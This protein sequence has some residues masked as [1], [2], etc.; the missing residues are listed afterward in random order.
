MGDL[1]LDAD[2]SAPLKPITD[3]PTPLGDYLGAQAGNALQ[4]IQDRWSYLQGARPDNTVIGYTPEG[5]AIYGSDPAQQHI[6]PDQAQAQLDAAGVKM[7]APASGMYQD[8][9]DSLVDR[10]QD[11]QARAAAIAGSPTGFRSVLGFGV[12]AA[13]SMLDPINVA[14]AF[15]PVIGP[16]KY[17]ALLA[18]AGSGL[19][20]FGIRAAVGAA[21]G[22]AGTAILQPFDYTTARNF[23][24]DFTM[25]N[26]LENVAFG[27]AFGAGLHSVGGAVHDLVA[28]APV[29]PVV[30]TDIPETLPSTPTN[31]PDISTRAGYQPITIK[32]AT[33]DIPIS[34]LGSAWM[35]NSVSHETRI[36]ATSTAVG[37]LLDG[38]NI[39][40]TPIIRADPNFQL[41]MAMR[42]QPTDMAGALAQAR[43]DVEPQLRADLT[44]QAGNQAD[45][46]AITQMRDQLDQINAEL[47][48]PAVASKED[49]RLLQSGQKLKF[50]DAQARAQD[51]LNARRA[52][53]QTQADRLTQAID[54]NRQASQAAQDLA[55]LD[56]G[57]FPERYQDRLNARAEELLQGDP[58]TAAIRQLYAPG[59]EADRT[60]AQAYNAPE[61]VAVADADMARAADEHMAQ[62][63][64]AIKTAG[65]EGAELAM[66]D[67]ET[68]FN[69]VLTNLKQAGASDSLIERF[70]RELEPFNADL[71]DSDNLAAAVR[72]AAICGLSHG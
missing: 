66:A 38:R 59:P 28:G 36:A 37:Q 51:E 44:A 70:Q 54:A 10:K 53:L 46:G 45:R 60:A 2:Y 40:V 27:A 13:T 5:L 9:I 15:V 26:A 63:P 61:N 58:L 68:R 57:G 34:P 8:T 67:A 55:T 48:Q 12:Q 33:G 3:Y 52:D 30:Q 72:A 47:A 35:N 20:R 22:A 49:I 56:G 1:V 4:N 6:A 17:T 19:A 50:S 43:T 69:D 29:K 7:T 14:S 32:L 21:E 23:G 39:E 64:E 31:A 41:Q 11:Q 24:D 42:Q 18:D 62:A 71:K 16:M 65:T 25:T